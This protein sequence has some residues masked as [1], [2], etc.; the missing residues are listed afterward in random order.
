MEKMKTRNADKMD[1][2]ERFLK[3]VGAVSDVDIKSDISEHV[4][5]AAQMG[6]ELLCAGEYRISNGK[7][8]SDLL[9]GAIGELPYV[10]GVYELLEVGELSRDRALEV[11]G[12][13]REI[14]KEYFERC[15][16]NV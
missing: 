12:E 4:R 10:K 15:G 5:T 16:V 11:L 6:M 7:D 14:Y 2:I 1:S 8:V 13:F 3:R 9:N